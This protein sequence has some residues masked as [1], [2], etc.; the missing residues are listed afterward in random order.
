VALF[1]L[2]AVAERGRILASASVKP[3]C[4]EDERGSSVLEASEVNTS[5]SRYGVRVWADGNCMSRTLGLEMVS[6]R[7][8]SANMYF[9]F[10][11]QCWNASETQKVPSPCW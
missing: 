3:A 1:S 8:W 11:P 10:I 4:Q 9:I 2:D 5:P 7:Y 6:S